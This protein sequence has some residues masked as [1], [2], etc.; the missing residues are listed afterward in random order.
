MENLEILALTFAV[1]ISFIFFGIT[2]YMQ[3]KNMTKTEYKGGGQNHG[4]T[5]IVNYLGDV[6]EDD[7]SKKNE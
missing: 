2:T 1:V 4:E 3:V 5:S 6:F 7:K